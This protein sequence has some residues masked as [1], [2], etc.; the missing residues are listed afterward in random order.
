MNPNKLTLALAQIA[1]VWLDRLATLEKVKANIQEA[2]QKGCE[3][4]VF[5]EGLLPGYPW[6]LSITHA[7][8]WDDRIQKEIHA[9]YARNAVQIER[10]DLIEIQK[11]ARQKKDCRLPWH[12]RATNRSGRAQSLLLFGLY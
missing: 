1:P 12:N 7:S 4:I 10:G 5:G 11:L 3:L 8:A 9:H 2:A 6:W